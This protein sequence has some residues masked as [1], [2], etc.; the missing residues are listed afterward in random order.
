MDNDSRIAR[1]SSIEL[2]GRI[3]SFLLSSILSP[4]TFS[5]HPP[6]PR[7]AIIGLLYIHAYAISERVP[8]FPP[9]AI[10]TS[11]LRTTIWFL[12]QPIPVGIAMSI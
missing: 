3:I 9:I 10:T 4:E 1:T 7:I 8:L 11:A 2:A 12:A 5:L 6:N